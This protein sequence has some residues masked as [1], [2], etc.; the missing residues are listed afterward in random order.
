M[1]SLIIITI[2]NL[3]SSMWFQI[4]FHVTSITFRWVLFLNCYK[5]YFFKCPHFVFPQYK[6]RKASCKNKTTTS[7]TRRRRKKCLRTTLLNLL[8]NLSERSMNKRKK[9]KIGIW[10]FKVY[11]EI[12]SLFQLLSKIRKPSLHPYEL[13]SNISNKILKVETGE[14][15]NIMKGASH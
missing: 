8:R 5:D 11:K 6:P 1:P 3:F 12:L 7:L 4:Y 13:S 2:T 14:L 10:R 9:F 15:R